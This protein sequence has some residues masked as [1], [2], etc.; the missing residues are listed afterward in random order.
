MLFSA[1]FSEKLPVDMLIIA[2]CL[3][4]RSLSI[5]I[6]CQSLEDVLLSNVDYYV[7]RIFCCSCWRNDEFRWEGKKLHV[8]ILCI[9]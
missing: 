4:Y 9:R 5:V 8:S 6:R 3:V 2:S 1:S 7:L